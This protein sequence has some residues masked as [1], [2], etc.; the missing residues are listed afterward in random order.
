MNGT[1]H[2]YTRLSA[3]EQAALEEALAAYALGALGEAEA[4]AVETHVVGCAACRA[5]A[6]ALTTT[7]GLLPAACDDFEPPPEL[8]ARLLAAVQTARAD[9]ATAAPARPPADRARDRSAAPAAPTELPATWQ[10]PTARPRR[11]AP[12]WRWA[13]PTAA[14]LLISLGLGAW[15]IQLERE[16]GR[17]REV[18]AVYQN[19]RQIW[20]LAGAGPAARATGML[21]EPAAGAPLLLAHDLPTLP[22]SQAYQA[23]VIRDGQPISARVFPA[24]AGGELLGELSQDV[25]GASTVAI[26]V[27]PAGGSAGPTGPIVL[28]ANL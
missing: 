26:T 16:L 12:G 28:A 10:G 17:E 4:T 7:V 14:L 23:W 21:V 20:R 18:V 2:D 22:A 24:G 15:N 1:P 27:E 3:A 8:K 19:A 13:L 11:G 6:A 25:A 5:R 9:T